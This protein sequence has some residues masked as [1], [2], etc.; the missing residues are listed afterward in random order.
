MDY[1]DIF[2]PLIAIAGNITGQIF[3]YKCLPGKKLLKSEY[4]GFLCGLIVLAV[5]QAFV[6]GEPAVERLS[7]IFVNLIIYGC[8]S[9][10]YFNFINMGETARRIRLLR[11]LYDSGL[12]LNRE[13]ILSRYNAE[14]VV[15]LRMRRLL[16]NHQIISRAGRYYV[17]SPVMLLIAKAI[18][19]A[20]LVVLGKKSE[21]E[22]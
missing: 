15:D 14:V 21:F 5:C 19:L 8:L 4:S 9:Y 20:K 18:V 22:R 7:L 10:C 6:H 17:G 13:E 12:G 11:E 2:I 3:S 1:F 16:N